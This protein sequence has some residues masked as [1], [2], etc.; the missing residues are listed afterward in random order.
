MDCDRQPSR[1]RQRQRGCDMP[2]PRDPNSPE[3]PGVPVLLDPG[4]V[5]R[6]LKLSSRRAA[7]EL[8][9]A[10]MEHIIVRRNPMTTP[11][12]LNQWVEQQR[13]SPRRPVARTAYSGGVDATTPL[14]RG[15]GS[16][17]SSSRRRTSRRAHGPAMPPPRRTTKRV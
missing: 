1:A 4:D 9:V 6:A 10:E 17:V 3:A 14:P 2:P 12:W 8:M 15:D 13:R 16:S 11:D 7:R 5:Q